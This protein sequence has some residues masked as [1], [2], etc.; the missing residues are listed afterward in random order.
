VG[1]ELTTKI[2]AFCRELGENTLA[3]LA[4]EQNKEAVFKRAEDALKAGEI[5][6]ALEADLDALDAALRRAYG[7]GLFQV[8]RGYTPL[9]P[10][11]GDS[12]ARWWTC[13]RDLCAG[14]G[15]VR[16]GQDPPICATAGRPLTAGPLPE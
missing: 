3:G 12:G 1:T 6:P 4:R 11:I 9:P 16:P 5:G 2:A 7:Q 10:Y 13:P 15:R 8:T 14:R